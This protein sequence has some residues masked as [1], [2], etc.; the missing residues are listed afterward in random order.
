MTYCRDMQK[1][2]IKTFYIDN[3]YFA[4]FGII[5]HGNAY[6]IGAYHFKNKKLYFPFINMVTKKRKSCNQNTKGRN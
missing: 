3:C 5:P 1:A 4:H 6:I 2:N